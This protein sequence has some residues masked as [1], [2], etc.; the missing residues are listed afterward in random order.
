[1]GK[2]RPIRI[3]ETCG[4][5]PTRPP[6]LDVEL[7]IVCPDCG[8]S[9]RIIIDGVRQDI[10]KQLRKDLKRNRFRGLQK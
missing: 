9:T 2:R 3:V 10:V 6:I 5:I 8:G 1:M 7:A 4:C